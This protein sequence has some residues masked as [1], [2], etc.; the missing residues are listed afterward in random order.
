[1][2]SFRA[3]STVNPNPTQTGRGRVVGGGVGRSDLL[4][5]IN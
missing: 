2:A 5:L 4:E 1:M 3:D